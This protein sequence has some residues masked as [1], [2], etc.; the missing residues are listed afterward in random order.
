VRELVRRSEHV[1]RRRPRVQLHR[2]RR[3]APRERARS[4]ALRDAQVLLPERD[5]RSEFLQGALEDLELSACQRVVR[6]RWRGLW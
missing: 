1:Q 2:P 4:C 3:D 6:Y 5:V